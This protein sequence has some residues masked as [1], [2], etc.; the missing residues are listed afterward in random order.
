MI[1]LAST[2]LIFYVLITCSSISL[3]CWRCRFL[4]FWR[5]DLWW[6]LL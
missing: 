5:H 4:W 3:F 1:H 2:K 6:S